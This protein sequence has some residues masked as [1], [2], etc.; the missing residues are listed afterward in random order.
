[1]NINEVT[2][3]VRERRLA[4]YS[5]DQLNEMIACCIKSFNTA[6]QRMLAVLAELRGEIIE[7]IRRREESERQAAGEAL[8]KRL[9]D[10]TMQATQEGTNIGRTAVR[11]AKLAFWAA[12]IAIIIALLAWLNPKAPN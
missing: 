2:V 1:M 6:D 7:E 11:Y 5:V 8:V 9:H 3:A 12:V 10:E 4:T